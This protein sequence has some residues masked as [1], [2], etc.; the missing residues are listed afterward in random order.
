MPPSEREC[1]WPRSA[2]M[3]KRRGGEVN[4]SARRRRPWRWLRPIWE[5]GEEK[6]PFLP[7]SFSICPAWR[8]KREGR[9]GEKKERPI[10]LLMILLRHYVLDLDAVD[11][12]VRHGDTEGRKKREKRGRDVVMF[13]H[14]SPFLFCYTR[15]AFAASNTWKIDEGKGRGRERKVEM[16]TID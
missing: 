8:P 11:F 14:I 15:I 10:S 6:P 12:Q 7:S 4:N 16:V 5:E 3:M 9:E 1:A 2:S 13:I